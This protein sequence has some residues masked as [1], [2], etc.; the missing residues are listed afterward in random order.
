[1]EKLM[2]NIEEMNTRFEEKFSGL[3]KRLDA[4]DGRLMQQEQSRSAGEAGVQEEKS[5]EQVTY[6]LLYTSPSPRDS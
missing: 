2:V 5:G 1:M 6:C 4:M 3:D